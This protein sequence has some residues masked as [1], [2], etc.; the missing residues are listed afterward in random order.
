M[1]RPQRHALSGCGMTAQAQLVLDARAAMGRSVQ[2]IKPF[3]HS[4]THPQA[5]YANS[6]D[7]LTTVYHRFCWTLIAL[8][9]PPLRLFLPPF[10]SLPLPR[11][12]S[13]LILH[14][15]SSHLLFVFVFFPL[16]THSHLLKDINTLLLKACAT[17]SVLYSLPLVS[18]PPESQYYLIPLRGEGRHAL[19]G[20]LPRSAVGHGAAAAGQTSILLSVRRC[21]Q[22][23]VRLGQT[24]NESQVCGSGS[25]SPRR[26]LLG[27]DAA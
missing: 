7:E 2:V 15:I 9:L 18:R 6:P 10:L 20:W 14:Y 1:G 25:E 21:Q 27:R 24:T 4:S 5:F 12:S 16:L 26:C 3:K 13:S 23:R 19:H 8:I 17:P 11:P 22:V